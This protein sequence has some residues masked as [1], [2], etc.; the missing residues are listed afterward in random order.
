MEKNDNDDDV[1]YQMKR[2]AV[3]IDVNNLL[4]IKNPCD[5]LIHLGN[6]IHRRSTTKKINW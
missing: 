2:Q 5:E 1:M 4:F 3:I 6:E